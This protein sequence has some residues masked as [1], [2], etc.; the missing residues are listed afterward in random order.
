MINNFRGIWRC[1]NKKFVKIIG[2]CV[3]ESRGKDVNGW[4]GFEISLEGE[5]DQA[6]GA[7]FWNNSGLHHSNQWDLMERK[8]NSYPDILKKNEVWPTEKS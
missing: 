8:P 2:D 3:F 4:I 1:R 6:S 5:L 7:L